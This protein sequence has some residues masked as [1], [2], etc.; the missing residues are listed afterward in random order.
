M[1]T[2]TRILVVDDKP[3]FRDPIAASLRLAGFETVC[4]SNG[5]EALAAVRAHRP[6]VVLLD[7]SMPVMDGVSCLRAIRAEPDIARTPVILFTALSDKKVVIEAGKLGVQDYLLKSSFSLKDLLARVL[8]YTGAPGNSSAAPP[9]GEPAVPHPGLPPGTAAPPAAVAPTAAAVETAP[10]TATATASAAAAPPAPAVP[11][12]VVA[13]A[14]AP[15]A[16]A[17]SATSAPPAPARQPGSEPVPQLLT[18][19]QCVA[20]AEKALAAKTLSGAVAEVISLAASPRGN[21]SDLAPLIARD[22]MLS[23]RVLQAANSAAYVSSRPVVST[24]PDAVRQIGTATVR[25]IAAAL[26]IFDVMPPSAPDGFNPIRCWQHSFAVAM[27]CERLSPKDGPDAGVSYLVGLC[28]DLGEIL[29]HTH[30]AREYAQVIDFH[31]RTGRRM[32]EV[33]RGMLGMTRGELVQTIIG[34]LGL[35]EAIKEPIRSFHEAQTNPSASAAAVTRVLRAAD[36]YANGLLLASSGRSTVAP[37]TKAECRAALGRD[38]PRHP[39]TATFRSE[40]YYTTGVLARLS[41]EQAQAVMKPQYD[42]TP[43]RLCVVRDQALSQFDPVTAALA[44]MAEVRAVARPAEVAAEPCDG[45]VV[46]ATSDLT[47]GFTAP[48]VQQAAAAGVGTAAGARPVLWLVGRVN[49]MT[50]RGASPAP[51]RWPVRLDDLAR[52]VHGCRSGDAPAAAA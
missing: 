12:P 19:E 51:Q 18:R 32:D 15:L 27:L 45:V 42:R 11:T 44:S 37:L 30:F 14:A 36:L 21:V 52:F 4:A 2:M 16:P 10:S 38:E 17:F 47:A 33:E 23:A 35:P 22:P 25:S 5:H 50:S 43:A 46:I 49:G 41:E 24:I 9:A 31:G 28:H 20:R 29:F 26:G 6:A 8:K 1:A 48:E 7:V 3:I 13:A 40:V 34:C 39:D